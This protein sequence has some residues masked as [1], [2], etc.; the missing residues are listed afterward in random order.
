MLLSQLLVVAA[1]SCIPGLVGVPLPSCLHVATMPPRCLLVSQVSSFSLSIFFLQASLRNLR[2]DLYLF[3]IYS[4]LTVRYVESWFPDL[5]S[6]LCPGPPGK[7]PF[8]LTRTPVVGLRVSPGQFLSD[9][10]NLYLQRPFSHVWSH[11]PV[12]GARA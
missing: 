10:P 8:S 9:I 12:L 4:F 2:L 5:G 7:F 11:L 6:N 1:V 3:V